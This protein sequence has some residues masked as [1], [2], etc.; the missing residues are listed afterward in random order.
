MRIER[1][2]QEQQEYYRSIFPRVPFPFVQL[3][4]ELRDLTYNDVWG[5]TGFIRLT[6]HNLTFDIIYD[7]PEI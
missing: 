1:D 4:R 2:F 6:W 5:H 3:P 7:S